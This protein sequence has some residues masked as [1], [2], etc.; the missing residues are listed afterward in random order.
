MTSSLL[1]LTFV[2]C[3]PSAIVH[4]LIHHAYDST[5]NVRLTISIS[6][7]DI[8]LRHPELVLTSCISYVRKNDKKVHSLHCLQ[9]RITL[10][11]QLDQGHR[12]QI[13]KA[14]VQVLET[15]RDK[16]WSLG[17]LHFPHLR[18]AAGGARHCHRS[19]RLF[20]ARDDDLAGGDGGRAGTSESAAGAAVCA[21][22]Q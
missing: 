16:V 11:A 9:L 19:G 13:L 3:L 17:V 10:C 7:H 20:G 18:N 1:F 21:V 15:S 14:M 4:Q 2:A 8:G 6:L 5:E 22:L 12:V